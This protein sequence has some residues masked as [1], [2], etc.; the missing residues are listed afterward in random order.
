MTA[1]PSRS[2]R[3]L[4]PALLIAL[5]AL[6][7]VAIAGWNRICAWAVVHAL[8]AKGLAPVGL[9]VRRMTTDRLEIVDLRLGQGELTADR[10]MLVFRAG[11]IWRGQWARATVSGL[12]VTGRRTAKGFS[13][14]VLDTLGGGEGGGIPLRQVGFDNAAVVLAGG[15]DQARIGFD[16]TLEAAPDKIA[17]A[18]RLRLSTSDTDGQEIPLRLSASLHPKGDGLAFAAR[19]ADA[20]DT[21]ALTVSGTRRPDGNGSAKLDLSPVDLAGDPLGLRLLFPVVAQAILE[22]SGTIAGRGRIAWSGKGLKPL[23]D[24]SFQNVGFTAGGIA[25]HGVHG[26]M[27]LDGFSPLSTPAGQH[28]AAARIT[29]GLALTDVELTFR[30]HAKGL[31]AERGTARLLGGRITAEPSRLA[32]D[33]SEGRFVLRLDD[34]ALGDAARLAELDGLDAE[35]QLDG[36]I[37]LALKDGALTLEDGTLAAPRRGRVMYRPAQPPAA[38]ADQEG[39]VGLLMQALADFHFTA[40]DVALSGPLDGNLAA[41]LKLTGG[42]PKVGG[43]QPFEINMTVSGPLGRIAEAALHS[44]RIPDTIIERL[45]AFGKGEAER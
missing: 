27:T 8:A 41:K 26:V 42:N 3:S 11:D 24:L 7:G 43:G 38:L 36:Q 34:L 45:T 12:T 6:A 40:L 14:G 29:A 15:K 5:L 30:L 35:G 17:V 37:V 9:T 33:G 39:G 18:A 28:L 2:R 21:V 31:E 10:V 23:I 19:L 16:G 4:L 44:Q 32:F 20:A 1:A 22:P 25:T 13:F